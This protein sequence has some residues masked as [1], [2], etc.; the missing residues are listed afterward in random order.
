VA[1]RMP[2]MLSHIGMLIAMPISGLSHKNRRKQQPALHH[3][4][5]KNSF[6]GIREDGKSCEM[7][8]GI[9]K[10]YLE[11]EKGHSKQNTRR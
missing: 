2:A 4:S 9:E 10:P 1:E 11:Q 8:E 7:T 6:P 5:P 3:P